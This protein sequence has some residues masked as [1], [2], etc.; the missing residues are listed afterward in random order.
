MLNKEKQ[1]E[2][3]IKAQERAELLS[4]QHTHLLLQW[5]T[6]VGKG[7]AAMQCIAASTST[8]PWLIVVPEILQIENY[9]RDM[10]KHGYEWLLTSKVTDIICYNSLHL[11][12][13]ME[14]NLALNEAHRMTDL[15][16]DIVK[17]IVFDQVISDSA[18]LP[19]AVKLI[20]NNICPYY[21]DVITMRDAIELGILPAPCVYKVAIKLDNKIKRNTVKRGKFSKQ[22]TDYEMAKDWD[23]QY[24]WWSNKHAE[25]GYPDWIGVKLQRIGGA[26]KKFLAE[27]KTEV[28]KKLLDTLENKRLICF[29][30]SIE[31]AQ[32]LGGK[33]AIHSKKS[34]NINLSILEDFNNFQ[35]NR[36]FVNKML[37]EGA[38]LEEIEAGIIVQ[39]DSGQDQGLSFLQKTGR[40]MR[41]IDP[42][43]FILYA[44]GTH[45]EVYLDRA[46]QHVDKQ[47]IKHYYV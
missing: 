30:G 37:K 9:K 46:L 34:K 19:S 27:R 29:C 21:A 4:K 2:E 7:K 42:E 22:L 15:R 24:R 20:L 39:L 35:F 33:H 26:R 31:Q 13:G 17:S 6:G 32:E 14:L 36:I 12:R 25:E 8:K 16:S 40:S 23:A 1:L 38:N 45:D 18:T 47:Y 11:Y 43:I 10:V 5:A 28:A 44:E 3:R 41:A